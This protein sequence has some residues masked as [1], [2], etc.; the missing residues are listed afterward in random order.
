MSKKIRVRFAPSPTGYLH[1]GGLRTAL[2]DYIYA[3][4]QNGDFILRIEDTDRN[5]YVEGAVENLIES[6]QKMG[7]DFDE[8]PGKEGDYG[9]YLQS[10]R[11]EIYQKYINI[12]LESGDAY[13]CFATK[14]ELDEMREKQKKEGLNPKY[15]GRYRNY[16]LEKAKKRIADGEPYVIRLK[17]RQEGTFVFYDKIRGKVEI[18]ASLMDDQVL[19]KSDGY[20][21][22]H[23]ASVVDD[24][25][26]EI[27]HV[28]RGEEWISSTPKHVFLYEC[29]GWKPPKWIH[30]P[31]ILN[32]DKTK[33]SKRQGDVAVED[34]LRKGYLPE[35][36]VNFITLLGWHPKTDKEI[37]SL[38]QTIK[39][40][41]FK[42]V[43]KAGAV[44]DIEKLN[45]MNGWYIRNSSLDRIAQLAKP[46]FK[47]ADINIEDANKYKDVVDL[48][49]GYANTLP[50]I[51]KHGRVFYQQIELDDSQLEYISDSDIK[52]MFEY[53]VSNIKDIEAWSE[54]EIGKFTKKIMKETGVKGKK[55]YHSMRLSL[56]GKTSGPDVPKIIK[57]LGKKGVIK[58]LKRFL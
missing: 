50:E 7:V 43:N 4:Q 45:W 35:A 28:I 15:D 51:V 40:F 22:Y 23:F 20:P 52:N 19:M 57:V 25:L 54:N 56:F 32:P 39:E 3:K 13:Y 44:F 14:D 33:L 16:P 30:L 42:R 29:F 27:S 38:P 26:M 8:G 18:D 11:L 37:I 48:A 36:L 10:N 34:Y 17:I 41:S 53:I 1:I 21:T 9:P 55:F 2:Y 46:Y 47:K 49:R 5:R 24:H 58:R 6:L 31:L 12:L